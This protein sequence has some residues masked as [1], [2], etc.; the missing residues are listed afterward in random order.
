MLERHEESEQKVEAA[1]PESVE[2][3]APAAPESAVEYEETFVTLSP[4]QEVQGTVVLVGADEVMVDVGHK[5]EGRILAKD[6]GLKS[7]E[8]PQDVVSVGDQITVHVL[9]VED[10]EGNVYLS[11]RLAD[12]RAAWERLERAK[13]A[14]ETIEAQVT[15]RVK[16]GL[17]ADVGVR[18]F[19]PAS[20]V[21]R[22]YV[23]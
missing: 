3:E 10:A 8:S 19:I 6:L 4:G 2:A 5:F 22:N 18:G 16:G 14:G 20:H 15:E 11:K 1:Q 21:S 23:D 7:G 13:E 12:Q 17:L 9:R